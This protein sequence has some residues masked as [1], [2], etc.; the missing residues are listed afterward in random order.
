M[1]VDPKVVLTELQR[2]ALGD[3]ELLA[4]QVKARDGLCD[5]VLDLEP[6]I[7]LQE[8]EG[9][10]LDQEFDRAGRDVADRRRRGDGGIAHAPAHRLVE[11]GRGRLLDDL[12]VSALNRAFALEAMDQVAVAVAQDLDFDMARPAEPALEIQ[13]VVAEGPR[14][15]AP[16]APDRRF[17]LGLA[18]HDAHALAATHRPRP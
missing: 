14:G 3:A 9:V 17:Q 15:F 2:L 18:S 13:G 6:G 5:R 11:R 12:L 10:A 7:H 4:H 1:A 8:P 16:G